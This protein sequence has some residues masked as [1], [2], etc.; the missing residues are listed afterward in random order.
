MKRRWFNVT[1]VGAVLVAGAVAAGTRALAADPDYTWREALRTVVTTNGLA[2]QSDTNAVTV[3]TVYT[4]VF[5]GQF[6]FGSAGTGTNAVWVAKGV[7]TNDWVQ[8][9]P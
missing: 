7:T 4:P 9:E 3:A 1:A 2:V 6:L 5:K 8:V